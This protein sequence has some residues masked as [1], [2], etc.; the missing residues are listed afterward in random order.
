MPRAAGPRDRGD[1]LIELLVAVVIM[2][3]AVVAIAGAFATGIRMSAIHRQQSLAG[4]YVR[5]FAEAVQT[6]V[7]ASP[8]GYVP[9]TV[10]GASYKAAYALPDTDFERDVV[11]VVYWN[12]VDSFVATCAPA[13]DSGVQR[14]T[15]SV[16]TPDRRVDERVD[17]IIRKPCRSTAEFPQD[18]LCG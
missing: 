4:S 13:S 11:A 15:L 1:T 9:C 8:T 3:V 16:H 6:A 14:V 17:V 18:T 5:S 2:T 10:D 12:G 7:A